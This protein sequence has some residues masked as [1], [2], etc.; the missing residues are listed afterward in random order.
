MA[1]HLSSAQLSSSMPVYNVVFIFG[2]E[3]KNTIPANRE[4][5]KCASLNISIVIDST[6]MTWNNLSL[7]RNAIYSS[8]VIV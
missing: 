8:T 4:A 5:I 1:G 6:R 3:I 7:D 2:A